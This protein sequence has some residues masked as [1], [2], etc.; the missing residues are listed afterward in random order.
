[1]NGDY[2][3]SCYHHDEIT[4]NHCFACSSF[5]KRKNMKIIIEKETIKELHQADNHN[6]QTAVIIMIDTYTDD[7]MMLLFTMI[8]NNE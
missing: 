1:M 3:Q 5:I 6:V 7:M 8:M 2:V 4:R